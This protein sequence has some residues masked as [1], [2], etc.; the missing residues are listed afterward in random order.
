MTGPI[1]FHSPLPRLNRSTSRPYLSPFQA[2]LPERVLKNCRRA[3]MRSVG[4]SSPQE[5]RAQSPVQKTVVGLISVSL[6]DTCSKTDHTVGRI[7]H[8]TS[9]VL[10]RKCVWLA[11]D[12]FD[13]L[14]NQRSTTT[15][16]VARSLAEPR[17][18]HQVVGD[19]QKRHRDATFNLRYIEVPR[20]RIP[21]DQYRVR[22]RLCVP[23]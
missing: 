9:I 8:N 13:Q 22:E 23:R 2:S 1:L 5:R 19:L 6:Q 11:D 18:I 3:R 4:R 16:G 21:L 15:K 20:C 12:R 14:P 10:Q 17:S 7:G